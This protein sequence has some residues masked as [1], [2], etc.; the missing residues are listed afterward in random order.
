[1]FNRCYTFGDT[2]V[3]YR[4]AP[5]SGH[6]GKTTVGLAILPSSVNKENLVLDSLVQVAFAGDEPLVSYSEGVTMRNRTSTLL[7]VVEQTEQNGEILTRLTDGKGNFYT[8]SLFY[9]EITGVFTLYTEYENRTGKPQILQM[10]S[11][12]SVSGVHRL[13]GNAEDIGL[14]RMT[15]AWS[16]ECRL[17]RDSFSDLGLDGSWAGQYGVK[18]ER[19]GEVGSMPNRGYYPFAAIEG[20]YCMGASIEAPYSWQAEAYAEGEL[21]ALSGGLGDFQFARIQKTV[22]NGE[23]FRTH[24]AFLCVKRG[25]NAVCNALVKHADA[26]LKVPAGEEELPVLF[27]EYCTT[28]GCPSMQNISDILAALR[29]LPVKT[30]VIDC[31]WYKPQGKEWAL[32][33]GDWEESKEL[34]PNGIS[35]AVAA[36]NGAG[37]QAGIWFEF[38]NA[39]RDSK[40]YQRE[41]LLLAENG[42]PVTTRNH[43]FLDLRLPA[44]KDYLNEKLFSFL[45]EKGFSYIKVDYNDAYALGE[46][47]REVAEESILFTEKLRDSGLAV[48]NCASGGSRIEPLRSSL[49]SMCSFSDAHECDEIPYVAANVSRVLPARQMQIWVVL[50]KDISRTV[51][52]LCAGFMGRI[53]LSGDIVGLSGEHRKTLSD[54]LQFYEKIRDV[55]R[56]GEI[57]N[58]D[59]TVRYYR[60]AKG[61]QIYEKRLGIK[62]LVIVHFASDGEV[63]IPVSGR[64][65]EA[66]TDLCYTAE[67]DELVIEGKALHAGAF[68][69]AEG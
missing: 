45:K 30:F 10:L 35:E 6:E 48:E 55:V 28:W 43:R 33:V 69:V 3:V 67:A 58:I 46:A 9:D 38:E 36:I 39:C 15:S 12:F 29:G 8:H 65:E 54:G 59:N 26:R 50:R 62:R 1:M 64:L 56:G 13:W 17:K 25:F 32:A 49:V 37:M 41:E 27:N 22:Q 20:E 66:F 42:K 11:S 47:G 44:A 63:R 7:K 24:R 14:I 53:C 21:Y 60:R 5:V 18:C 52:L 40:L 57:V 19:W 51:Y 61:R 68:L 34:F 4:E 2:Q 16:R 31:G 23:V